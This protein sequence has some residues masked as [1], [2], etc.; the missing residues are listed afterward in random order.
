L[1]LGAR[2]A[3]LSLFGSP[4][5]PHPPGFF[6]VGAASASPSV[7][8][9]G[10]SS[11]RPQRSRDSL[12]DATHEDSISAEL[13]PLQE[14]SDDEIVTM[15]GPPRQSTPPLTRASATQKQAATAATSA[16]EAADE[17]D[18]SLHATL[19]QLLRVLSQRPV[20]VSPSTQPL[21][22]LQ[23]DASALLATTERLAQ[24]RRDETDAE[25]RR[26]ET[27][28][29]DEEESKA[30]STTRAKLGALAEAVRTTREHVDSGVIVPLSYAFSIP[31]SRNSRLR[32][33]L[34]ILGHSLFLLLVL[35]LA[36]AGASHRFHTTY[37]D[38]FYP[39]LFPPSH[40]SNVLSGAEALLE[41]LPARSKLGALAAAALQP[42]LR[43]LSR[44]PEQ[45]PSFIS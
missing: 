13:A 27:R 1:A 25:R 36:E 30:L 41:A 40:D 32:T 19:E 14:A 5:T 38:P 15:A 39:P 35:Y 29:K 22:E 45:P 17:K 18:P 42:L 28:E 44:P 26:A 10:G 9:L 4:G 23:L 24:L 33:A 37:Y 31:P 3:N 16:H 8:R 6:G 2:S 43:L 7:R 11:L 21:P 12:I 34:F 20:S